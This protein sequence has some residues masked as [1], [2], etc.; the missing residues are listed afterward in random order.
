M[1]QERTYQLKFIGFGTNERPEV[2][3]DGERIS[4]VMV[5]ETDGL[6]I[7]ISSISTTSE[8][9]VFFKDVYLKQPNLLAETFAFLDAAQINISDKDKAMRAVKKGGN[10]ARVINDIQSIGLPKAVEGTLSEILW[11]Y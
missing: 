10:Q 9:V 5:E 2:Q 3:V 4:P 11:A 6:L 1:P 7:E 8:L